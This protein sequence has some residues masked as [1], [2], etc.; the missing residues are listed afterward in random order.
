MYKIIRL[1]LGF[2]PV[3]VITPAD[4]TLNTPHVRYYRLALL[5]IGNDQPDVFNEIDEETAMRYFSG[6]ADGMGFEALPEFS[7]PT[8]ADAEAYVE[9]KRNEWIR[10]RLKNSGIESEEDWEKFLRSAHE[11]L[12]DP[13]T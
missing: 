3:I 13:D 4:A 5:P 1:G 2:D 11:T 9:E 8:L 10:N 7:F 12:S 6:Q